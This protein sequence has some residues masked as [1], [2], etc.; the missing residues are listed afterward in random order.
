[1]RESAMNASING[2]EYT[3]EPG[4]TIL[5]VARRNDIFIPTL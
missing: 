4:E 1:M 2:R 5:Q 3:F